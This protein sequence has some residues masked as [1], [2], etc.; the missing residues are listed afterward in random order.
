VTASSA[1]PTNPD[2]INT[3]PINTD[4][5]NADPTAADPG[6]TVRQDGHRGEQDAVPRGLVTR[7]RLAA[8]LE[9][10]GVRRG[11]VLLVHASLSSLGWVCGGPVAVV[12]ALLDVLGPKGTLVVPTHSGDNSDPAA[13]RHPPV[14]ES[15]WATIRAELPGF[16]P[17]VTPTRGMGAIADTV[18]AWPV[19]R[20]SEHPQVSFAAVGPLADE[21]TAKHRLA[22]QLGEGSPLS[23][24][25]DA[26]GAVLLLGVGHDSNTSLHLAEY[27]VPRLANRRMHGAA[28]LDKGNRKWVTWDDLDLDASDFPDLGAAYD[29]TG[30]VRLAPVGA[31]SSRL[32]DQGK[33]V[34]FA[35]GWLAQHR[36]ATAP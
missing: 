21:L 9:K 26:G 8:D 22:P 10:L 35:A 11:S 27:A 30:E 12:Q 25:R 16:H 32:M 19:A 31:A 3:D 6:R 15:W 2:P 17:K 14:P 4:P 23:K 1:A 7:P 36:P 13:W 33:L 28:I 34:G 24:I 5:I 29:A 18:R 20:R